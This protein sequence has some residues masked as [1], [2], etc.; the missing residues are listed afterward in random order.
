MEDINEIWKKIKKG[1]T[2]AAGKVISKEERPQTNSGLMKN[3][4]KIGEDREF[5]TK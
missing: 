5:T 1:I 3:V 4:K 2:E